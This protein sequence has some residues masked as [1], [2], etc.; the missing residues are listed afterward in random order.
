MSH[1]GCPSESGTLAAHRRG[2]VDASIA[3]HVASCADCAAAIAVDRALA[4]IAAAE[5]PGP[6]P[7]AT[8]LR[9]EGELRTEERRLARRGRVLIALQGGGL[10]LSLALL[11]SVRVVEAGSSPSLFG[12]AGSICAIVTVAISIWNLFRTADELALPS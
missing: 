10:A 5:D 12:G 4:L 8:A 7:A 3:A 6:Y 2:A 9:L 11:A 1:R